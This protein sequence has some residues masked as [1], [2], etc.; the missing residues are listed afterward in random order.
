MELE[1][2]KEGLEYWDI[3]WFG[4]DQTGS[5]GYFTTGIYGGLPESIIESQ[6]NWEC[7]GDFL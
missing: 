1:F 5:I 2:T 4:I 3:V 6:E 7:I